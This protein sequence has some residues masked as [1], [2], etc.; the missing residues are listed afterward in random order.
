MPLVY[1]LKTIFEYLMRLWIVFAG[2][3]AR[4]SISQFISASF[5][6]WNLWI[7]C[8]SISTY[9]LTHI[10][11]LEKGHQTPTWTEMFF[12]KKQSPSIPMSLELLWLSVLLSFSSIISPSHLS[13]AWLTFSRPVILSFIKTWLSHLHS[14]ALSLLVVYY[15]FVVSMKHIYIF[16]LYT[17]IPYQR[18][19]RGI[20]TGYLTMWQCLAF[21]IVNGPQIN[22]NG[23]NWQTKM[24]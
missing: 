13:H 16:F 6:S 19:F 5:S 22:L 4:N 18:M 12:V 20:N 14:S 10:E 8:Q 7:I 24:D 23:S 17:Q 2:K 15:T 21:M 9:S 11:S 1:C 3:Q